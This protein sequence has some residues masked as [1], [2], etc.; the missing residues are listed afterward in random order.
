MRERRGWT[1]E[2]ARLV[3]LVTLTLLG[4]ELL[5]ALTGGKTAE[6]PAAEP[7]VSLA[8]GYSHG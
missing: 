2:A 4:I 8:G 3:V 1:F 7:N 5:V 6:K